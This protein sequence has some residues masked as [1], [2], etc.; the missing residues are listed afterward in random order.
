MKSLP[1][2][3]ASPAGHGRRERH[4]CAKPKRQSLKKNMRC[5]GAK[6]QVAVN[7]TGERIASP[8]KGKYCYGI[9]WRRI[10][11]FPARK[12]FQFFGRAFLKE[13][14][15]GREMRCCRLCQRHGVLEGEKRRGAKYKENQREKRRDHLQDEEIPVIQIYRHPQTLS[16]STKIKALPPGVFGLAGWM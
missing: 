9:R 14:N 2:H 15:N 11:N 4:A 16:H 10:D 7:T 12:Q 6:L 1:H 3:L 13:K 8:G 5:R